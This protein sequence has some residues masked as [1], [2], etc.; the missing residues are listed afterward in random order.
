MP[1][2]PFNSSQFWIPNGIPD[3]NSTVIISSPDKISISVAEFTTLTLTKLSLIGN[4]QLYIYGSLSFP[5]VVNNSSRP[6]LYNASLVVCDTSVV[7]VTPSGS[8][9]SPFAAF[10]DQSAFM[11]GGQVVFDNLNV[12]GSLTS[13]QFYG[14]S[15]TIPGTIIGTMYSFTAKENAFI[16]NSI[17][18]IFANFVSVSDMAIVTRYLVVNVNGDFEG[19]QYSVGIISVAGNSNV[20]M[21]GCANISYLVVYDSGIATFKYSG[22]C[23][24]SSVSVYDT[25]VL[26]I[27]GSD[28]LYI[29]VLYQNEIP[30]DNGLMSFVQTDPDVI[31][32]V[33]LPACDGRV[34][35]SFSGNFNVTGGEPQAGRNFFPGILTLQEVTMV[36][37]NVWFNA[38]FLEL[39]EGF[40][41]EAG[42]LIAI[43]SWGT[44][45]IKNSTFDLQTAGIVW[46]AGGTIRVL[47]DGAL[48]GDV[49]DL[50]D[51]KKIVFSLDPQSPALIAKSVTVED[52]SSLV[53]EGNANITASTVDVYGLLD[54]GNPFSS[55][56]TLTGNINFKD[57]AVLNLPQTLNWYYLFPSSS[58]F[59]Q[60][61]G[62]VTLGGVLNVSLGGQF[63]DGTSA[64][65]FTAIDIPILTATNIMGD[66][67]SFNGYSLYSLQSANLPL[68]YKIEN[69]T[70][71]LHV[72]RSTDKSGNTDNTK[73]IIIG[74]AGGGALLAIVVVSLI[75][76]KCNT[77]KKYTPIK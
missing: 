27:E 70:V 39:T 60:V 43:P 22:P 62:E 10:F 68:S 46:L 77:K 20:T 41:Y 58:A 35:L 7:V 53:F 47:P 40:Q 71:W 54:I 44:L 15:I 49:I 31:T 65:N 73:W 33:F 13:F 2:A 32:R 56:V 51:N 61:N 28:P 69:N 52:G 45:F 23:S 6:T 17:S 67:S 25:S 30:S 19:T 4:I 12:T 21:N 24:L 75:V 1:C 64:N 36:R 76:Y 38:A 8:L 66:F 72:G 11:S 5:F 57:T 34:R 37:G 16:D 29:E 50:D 63:S 26:T 59:L 14:N 48:Q 18:T 42:L 9:R 3:N 55:N 74:A